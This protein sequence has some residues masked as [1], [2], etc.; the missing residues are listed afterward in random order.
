V[1]GLR[2]VPLPAYSFLV[3]MQMV[4]MGFSKIS[5]IEYAIDTEP[6]VEGGVNSYVRSLVTPS[7][8]EKK[9]VFERGI[10]SRMIEDNLTSRFSVGS[11]LN[12]PVIII[13]KDING[14]PSKMYELTGGFVKKW[15]QSDLDASKGA[16]QIE[17]IEIVYE[18]IE[19]LGFPIPVSML[20]KFLF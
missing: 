20:S 16:I 7:K 2:S 5:S 10:A 18:N 6:L 4:P 13:V 19:V 17:K 15:S 11:R 12:T 3:F 8:S 9:M 14:F 1:L